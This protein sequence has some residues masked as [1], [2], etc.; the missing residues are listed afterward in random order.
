MS[1]DLLRYFAIFA[2][3]Y[4]NIIIIIISTRME[5]KE[6]GGVIKN[7]TFILGV[8]MIFIFHFL[9][10]ILITVFIYGNI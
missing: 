5:E 8:Y 1:F 9:I 10:S 2:H 6:K 3:S 7:V 4:Y